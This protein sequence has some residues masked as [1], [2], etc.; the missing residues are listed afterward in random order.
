MPLWYDRNYYATATSSGSYNNSTS[1]AVAATDVSSGSDIAKRP[2]WKQL[3]QPIRSRTAGPYWREWFREKRGPIK[4]FLRQVHVDWPVYNFPPREQTDIFYYGLTHVKSFPESL[5]ADARYKASSRLLDQLKGEGTNVAMMIAERRQSVSMVTNTVKRL[6]T[7]ALYL[8]RGDLTRAV[9]SF[10]GDPSTAR[11]LRGKDIGSQWLELQYGWK[12]LLSDVH[13]LMER[14]HQ[15]E[16]HG[17]RT[18]RA[19]DKAFERVPSGV[20]NI[21]NKDI[22]TA[23]KM[24]I[25]RYTLRVQPDWLLLEP[26]ALGV[27]DPLTIAWE[28]VPW[29]FVVDWFLPVGKYLG[30]LS[31]DHGWNFFDGDE[32][33]LY[34]TASKASVAGT[35]PASSGAYIGT[36]TRTGEVSYEY[37]R[38]G[39]S[40]LT[41]IP[42]CP[43]IRLKNPVSLDHFWNSIA[44]LSQ[45]TKSK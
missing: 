5:A 11:K 10:G 23:T 3:S 14:T 37:T 32:S 13:G 39:R 26:S 43:P 6:A 7:S 8:K 12:P 24:V 35:I 40:P 41:R 18:F 30:Q 2:N 21:A 45:R 19:S 25:H 9:R 20:L 38:F 34:Q 42:P 36:K 17:V 4:D 31:A 16:V 27:T 44:L 28:L 29:S 15:R 22:S 1:Q 33:V